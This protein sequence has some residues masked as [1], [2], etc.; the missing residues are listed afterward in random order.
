MGRCKRRTCAQSL[1]LLKSPRPIGPNLGRGRDSGASSIRCSCRSRA[2]LTPPRF[3]VLLAAICAVHEFGAAS[4]S[5]PSA[6]VVSETRAP[7]PGLVLV[8]AVGR[9]LHGVRFVSVLLRVSEDGPSYLQGA[10]Y[11]AKRSSFDGLFSYR[12]PAFIS[13]CAVTNGL[14]PPSVRYQTHFAPPRC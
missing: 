14:W 9:L 7:A 3:L 11:F 6:R 5:A 8:F 12:G 2:W 1:T 4:Q 10:I 13:L